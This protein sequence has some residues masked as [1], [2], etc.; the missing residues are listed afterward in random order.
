M[1]YCCHRKGRVGIK[2]YI[3][4]EIWVGEQIKLHVVAV[5][6]IVICYSCS[7]FYELVYINCLR[8][9][10][11][12]LWLFV[13]ALIDYQEQIIPRVLTNAGGILWFLMVLMAVQIG[14]ST[15][16]NVLFFSLGGLLLGGGIFLL[17]RIFFR[18][19]VGMGDVRMFS[20]IGLLYGS[21]YTFS[22]LFFT[23]LFMSIY[24]VIAT[25]R[26]KKDMKASVAMG[27]FTCV[28]YI[29]CIL[30]GI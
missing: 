7:V 3:K 22:I 17:C 19:G 28:A 15:V 8:N 27:P 21:N 2:Q 5:V 25:V 10:W 26:K 23:I 12:F 20:V 14:G 13:I 24:G 30:L 11:V 1:Y 18:G 4:K 9:I 29:V 6:G 16:K